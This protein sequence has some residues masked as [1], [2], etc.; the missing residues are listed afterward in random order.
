MKEVIT[1]L[2]NLNK[3]IAVMESCTG[4]AICNSITDIEGASNVFNY[5]AV[6][7]SN[8]AKIKMGVR[9]EI[10]DK[11][12]VYSNETANEMSKTIS[13]FTN[14]HY[15]V[16]V[17]GKLNRIDKNN[18]YGEDNIVYISIYDRDNNKFY[19]KEVKVLEDCRSQNKQLVIDV[20]V[21]ELL[22]IIK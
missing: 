17:T 11:Y 5:G 19:N 7:Y 1:I 4:G 13:L 18:L 14:S 16:G 6:T 2:T 9:K 10:I 3:T 12:T 22:K 8:N 20:I 21:N 15:G